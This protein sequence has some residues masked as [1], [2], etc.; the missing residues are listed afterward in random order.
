MTIDAT[1]YA[2]DPFH[3][4]ALVDPASVVSAQFMGYGDL[5]ETKCSVV[6]TVWPKMSLIWS[7]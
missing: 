4:G 6:R 2:N 7:K 5:D 3:P 1:Q